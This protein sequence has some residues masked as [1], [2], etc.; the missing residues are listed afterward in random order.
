[1]KLNVETSILT[2]TNISDT[3]SKIFITK[4][5]RIFGIKSL[6]GEAH[7][8]VEIDPG[9]GN[10]LSSLATISTKEVKNIDYSLSSNKIF[11]LLEDKNRPWDQYLY[12]L[13]LTDGTS[14]TT[15][16]EEQNNH[17]NFHGIYLND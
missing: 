2:S 17:A 15:Q 1:M 7:E 14:T 9:S 10:I 8:I 4:T 16:L 3:Y 5:E 12:E 13:S 11:A 6:G